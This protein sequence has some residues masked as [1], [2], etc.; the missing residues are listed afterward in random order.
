MLS[1][2]VLSAPIILMYSWL[3]VASFSVRITGL[4]PHGFT[5]ENWRF[6]GRALPN[7]ASIWTTTLNSLLFA[8]A[9]GILEVLIGSMAAYA[10]S[11][12]NFAGRG[13][14]LS[15]TMVLHSFPSVTL[16]IAIFLV[17]RFLGLYDRLAGVILVKLALDLPLGIWIMKGFFDNVPWDIEM[18]ASSTAA[19]A[20]GSGGALWC[21]WSSLGSWPSGSSPS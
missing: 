17:L 16:L 15:S 19:R 7:E 14:V 10:L 21:P 5:L 4:V 18:A 12:L 8:F 1:L 9:V 6:L 20:S 13:V 11:R 2:V 3:L